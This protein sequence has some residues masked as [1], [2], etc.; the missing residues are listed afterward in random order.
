VKG[1]RKKKKQRGMQSGGREGIRGGSLDNHELKKTEKR[2]EPTR[3][4]LE[5]PLRET[6]QRRREKPEMS[7]P[8]RKK[9]TASS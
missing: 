8:F 9:K 2:G 3:R 4:I 6:E 7:R 5:L 1:R